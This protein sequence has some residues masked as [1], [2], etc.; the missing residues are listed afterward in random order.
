L[1]DEPIAR[2][3]SR[4]RLT[5]LSLTVLVVSVVGIGL[6]VIAGSSSPS[7]GALQATWTPLPNVGESLMTCPSSLVSWHGALYVAGEAFEQGVPTSLSPVVWRLPP[8]GGWT[9]VFGHEVASP[10]GSQQ[11][12]FVERGHLLLLDSDQSSIGVWTSLNVTRWTAGLVRFPGSTRPDL[13]A[14][15]QERNRLVAIVLDNTGQPSERLYR[16]DD[17]LDWLPIPISGDGG[18]VA[19]AA[20]RS[21]YVVAGATS[22]AL[23]A[24]WTSSDGV[25]WTMTVLSSGPGSVERVAARGGRM[26]ATGYAGIPPASKGQAAWVRT[27]SGW[28]RGGR[29]PPALERPI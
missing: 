17:G 5:L 29:L 15:A 10:G 27:S 7:S 26:V 9:K 21:G 13:R 22:D 16:S 4:V 12:V 28:R 19:A 6:W 14:V 8:R 1:A 11:W 20:G 18:L 25:R 23:P 3:R 2:P 24:V